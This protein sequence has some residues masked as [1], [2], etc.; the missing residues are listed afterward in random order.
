LSSHVAAGQ[1]PKPQ[2]SLVFTYSLAQAINDEVLTPYEYFPHLVE[3]TSAEAD[4]FVALSA[5]IGRLMAGQGNAE[6]SI[7][8]KA[9]MMKRARVIASARNKIP[10]LRAV[11]HHRPPQAHALFYCGDGQVECRSAAYART[12]PCSESHRPEPVTCLGRAPS[13]GC[14]RRHTSIKPQIYILS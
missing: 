14:R 6:P 3:L 11:L 1:H 12:S 9:L 7:G 8:L 4:E 13:E 5:E 2:R 10:A